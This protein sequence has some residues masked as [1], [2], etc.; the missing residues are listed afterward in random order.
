M[1]DIRD[2][3]EIGEILLARGEK[4][5]IVEAADD[6]WGIDIRR[7]GESDEQVKE[8]HE[9]NKHITGIDRNGDLA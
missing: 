7:Y 1:R 2:P 8:R 6:L 3:Q 9:H 4:V 5:S